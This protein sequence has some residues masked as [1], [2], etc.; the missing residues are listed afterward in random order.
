MLDD[1]CIVKVSLKLLGTIDNSEGSIVWED[2]FGI[3]RYPVFWK[4]I[5]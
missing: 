1:H 5:Y 2:Q 4:D 3:I